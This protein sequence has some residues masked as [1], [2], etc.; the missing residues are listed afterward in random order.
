MA[1][2]PDEPQIGRKQ[3]SSWQWPSMPPQI[4]VRPSEGGRSGAERLVGGQLDELC[5]VFSPD[6]PLHDALERPSGAKHQVS[7]KKV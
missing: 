7:F 6:Y 3:N 5:D 2:T 4:E 1:T